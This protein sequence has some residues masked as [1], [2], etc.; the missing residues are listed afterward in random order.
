MTI[1]LFIVAQALGFF[2]LYLTWRGVFDLGFAFMLVV[3]MLGL[4]FHVMARDPRPD[5][6]SVRIA[7]FATMLWYAT[8]LSAKLLFEYRSLAISVMAGLF[9][10]FVGSIAAFATWSVVTRPLQY[11][12]EEA[13]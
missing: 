13:E 10:V 1:V 9:M 11:D 2:G 12:V 4:S 7:C 5:A 6:T 3:T 8:F